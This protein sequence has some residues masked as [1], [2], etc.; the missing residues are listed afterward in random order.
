VGEISFTAPIYGYKM[1]EA[2]YVAKEMEDAVFAASG[3]TLEEL[4]RQA[5]GTRR[6]G[7]SSQKF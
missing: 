6:L 4:R 2:R 5:D 7:S 3:I 1:R